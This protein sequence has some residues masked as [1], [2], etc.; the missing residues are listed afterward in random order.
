MKRAPERTRKL[1][2][3]HFAFMRAVAQGLDARSAW[4]RYLRLEGEHVDTR[5]VNSTIAWIRSE[6]AAAARSQAG[7]SA[8]GPHRCVVAAGSGEATNP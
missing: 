4:D 6:F 7:D 1:H 3:G 2:S 8:L 5:K